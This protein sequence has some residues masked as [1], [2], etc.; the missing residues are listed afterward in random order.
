MMG[1]RIAALL[2]CIA[3]VTGGC[4]SR[5]EIQEL[6]FVT[7]MAL[8]WDEESGEHIVTLQI[9]RI[10]FI[11]RPGERASGGLQ[12]RPFALVTARGTTLA[13][14]LTN[15]QQTQATRLYYSQMNGLVVGE[16]AARQGISDALGFLWRN[17]EIRPY[18]DIMVARGTGM[19]VLGG[20]PAGG[21][22]TGRWLMGLLERGRIHG[23][24]GPMPLS[25]VMYA[26]LEPGKA[27]ALPVLSLV[28]MGTPNPEAVP[29]FSEMKVE[30][31]AVMDRDRVVELLTPA[32]SRGL[33]FLQGRIA[34]AI[35]TGEGG[36]T[37]GERYSVRVLSTRVKRE[38]GPVGQS[39]LPSIT[40]RIEAR[41]EVVQRQRLPTP[42]QPGDVDLL[43]RL[44]AAQVRK[45]AEAALAATKRAGA[46]VVGFGETLRQ[47]RPAL[48]HSVMQEWDERYASLPVRV[49][50]KVVMRR[51][52]IIR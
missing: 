30:G 2:L 39:G 45:E 1:R 4:W 31:M 44:V 36:G 3:F 11:A 8:D 9:V 6:S 34:S 43:G 37:P 16:A 21:E 5:K 41:A 22:I 32:E 42:L 51:T 52:G 49:E 13:E 29:E 33:L 38:V 17:N 46:D 40:V 24:A 15:V 25:A 50:V 26:T 27:A 48:W 12:N 23:Y 7:A 19:E 18:I 28:R 47:R 35:I 20:A 10:Q 14:A